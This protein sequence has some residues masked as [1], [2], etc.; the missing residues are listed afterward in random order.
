M[1]PKGPRQAAID[2]DELDLRQEAL[3]LRENPAALYIQ[4]NKGAQRAAKRGLNARKRAAKSKRGG[5]TT[6]EAGRQGIGSGVARARD[7]AA[8]KRVDAH[9]VAS[10]FARH[11]KS[12]EA[13]KAKGLQPEQSPAIQSWLMW[14]GDALDRQAA[15]E[16]ARSK[17]A[18]PSSTRKPTRS[19]PKKMARKRRR[20]GKTQEIYD[21]AIESI[22]R[23]YEGGATFKDIATT[24]GVSAPTIKKWLKDLGYVHDKTGRYPI[25]MQ[26]RARDLLMEGWDTIAISNLL[27][28]KPSYV[29]GWTG[30]QGEVP[31][32]KPGFRAA[33][34]F[35]GRL[36]KPESAP[37]ELGETARHA[38]GK[39]WTVPQKEQ[40]FFF[41][42]T[43]LLDS[44]R[45][46]YWAT[47]ASRRRQNM[48]WREYA[49]MTAPFPFPKK[50]RDT[51]FRSG[52]SSIRASRGRESVGGRGAAPGDHIAPAAQRG[53]GAA[54]AGA[55]RIG[56]GTTGA[57]SRPRDPTP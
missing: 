56:H 37:L 30:Q 12:Y 8:G 54:T 3:E 18:S 41:L 42:S 7:I 36:S 22:Q 11:R 4:P 33:G 29:M 27:K 31:Q 50:T 10:F 57:P 40:V 13:A 32:V 53:G 38:R 24:W 45:K 17:S 2:P 28:V 23:A 44:V 46:I 49:P 9:R 35:A 15:R 25:A 51:P 6:Q 39:W 26:G 14:G 55:A 47:G 19:N 1:R 5:L 43:G 52:G 20:W 48:I 16:I 21:D 34:R